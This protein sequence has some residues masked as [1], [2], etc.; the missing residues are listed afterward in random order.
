MLLLCT[1]LAQEAP[2]IT[3][4]FET[5]GFRS[6]GSF[7]AI[8]GNNGGSFCSGTL[9]KTRWAI[10]AAH[11]LDAA[12]D[13]LN[14]GWT[15]YFVVTNSVYDTWDAYAEVSEMTR[16]PD[17]SFDET[18]IDYDI[19][20]LKLAEPILT[21]GLMPMNTDQVLSS[22]K[23]EDITY[24]GFGITDTGREDGGIKRSVNIPLF[25]Y[26]GQFI[27]T[28][29]ETPPVKNVCSGDSGGAALMKREQDDAWELVGVNS[30]V[31]NSDGSTSI[32]CDAPGS[33]AAASR[34]DRNDDFLGGFFEVPEETHENDADTDADT[35]TDT[36]TDTDGDSDSEPVDSGLT[37]SGLGGSPTPKDG[38][39]TG[40]CA[41]VSAPAWL[42]VA[43][44]I[45]LLRRRRSQ[46]S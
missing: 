2:P 40:F 42:A 1:A 35:D 32:D 7:T 13:Y 36:D 5:G 43:G 14:D 11:C 30:F 34:V 46:S 10:T 33:G 28:L 23:G 18:N 4:G 24:V 17:Y 20:V 3:N 8:K 15:L 31:W 37:D 45:G 12:D 16:H 38:K 6:V 25:E 9:V 41:P 27:Y 22:W 29:D 39:S 21:V 26:D 19:G 44:L